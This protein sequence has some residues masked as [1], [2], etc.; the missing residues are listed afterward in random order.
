MFCL[1]KHDVRFEC[2]SLSETYTFYNAKKKLINCFHDSCTTCGS[3]RICLQSGQGKEG[4]SP[5]SA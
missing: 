3:S 4:S 5:S 2:E 1:K